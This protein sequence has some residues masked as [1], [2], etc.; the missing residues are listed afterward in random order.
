MVVLEAFVN[1]AGD[2]VTVWTEEKAKRIENVLAKKAPRMHA[3]LAGLLDQP[4]AIA[5]QVE[6]VLDDYPS[7]PGPDLHAR[8]RGQD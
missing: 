6:K 8:S 4:V 1:S 3:A 5:A 7:C 2:W